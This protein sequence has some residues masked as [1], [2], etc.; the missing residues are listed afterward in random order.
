MEIYEA[1]RKGVFSGYWEGTREEIGK[2]WE[3]G[4]TEVNGKASKDTVLN[5]NK[6]IIKLTGLNTQVMGTPCSGGSKS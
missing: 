2:P 3:L 1:N 6:N 5:S 4:V